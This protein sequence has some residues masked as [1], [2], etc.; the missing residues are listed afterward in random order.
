MWWP[1]LLGHRVWGLPRILKRVLPNVDIEGE[2]L[3]RLVPAAA[4]EPDA[5]VPQLPGGPQRH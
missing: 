5:T 4:T 3:S 2:K 1:R